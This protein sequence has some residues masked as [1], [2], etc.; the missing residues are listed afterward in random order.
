[1]SGRPAAWTVAGIVAALLAVAT[2][3]LLAGALGEQVSR[4]I[5]GLV[6]LGI[7]L[8]L[9]AGDRLPVRPLIAWAVPV[10]ALTCFSVLWG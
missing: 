2:L 6:P 5:T 1:M 10:G 9:W 3:H 4:W 7:G 8:I